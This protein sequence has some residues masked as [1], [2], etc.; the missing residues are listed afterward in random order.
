MTHLSV[1]NKFLPCLDRRQFCLNALAAGVACVFPALSTRAQA[2]I[3]RRTTQESIRYYQGQALGS[4]LSLVLPAIASPDAAIEHLAQVVTATNAAFSPYLSFSEVSKFNALNVL[5]EYRF[6]R[7]ASPVI[8]AALQ[9]ANLTGGVFDPT[10]G[11][12]V[13]RWGHGP[14][15]GARDTSFRDIEQLDNDQHL[16][17]YKRRNGVTLDCCGIAKGFALQEMVEG[18]LTL[19]YENFFLELG[20]EVYAA[21]QH[22]A[23]RPWRAG[24]ELPEHPA[25]KF[26]RNL[27]QRNIRL[28]GIVELDQQSI[29]TSGINHN[30]FKFGNRIYH[31][32]IN[33]LTQEP[34]DSRLLSVSV[35]HRNAMQADCWS[36]TLLATDENKAREFIRR[37]E[38]SALL[39]FQDRDA[40]RQEIYGSMKLIEL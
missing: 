34:S 37:H 3:D 10:V 6:S 24:I 32:I 5:G 14:I 26:I 8:K 1:D 2:S 36:T 23:G 38:L 15:T 29:A 11:P 22:P 4:A 25:P 18:L 9:Q 33:P 20:G 35:L 12:S 13:S 31:H 16:L 7:Y 40:V 27:T 39:L 19:G 30:A 28:H 21:G 17:L